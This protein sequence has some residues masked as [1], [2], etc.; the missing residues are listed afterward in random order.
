MATINLELYYENHFRILN[1]LKST[2]ERPYFMQKVAW[3]EQ[4]IGIKG[5]RGVGKTT[6]LLHY[7]KQMYGTN[8][9]CLYIS[10][11]QLLFSGQRL[12]DIADAFDKDGGKLLCVDEIHRYENWSQELKNIYDSYPDLKVIFTGSS[13]LHIHKGK[14]DLSRRAVVYN[15]EG[16]SF[17]EYLQIT[18]GHAFDAVAL[19]DLLK[20]HVEI[21]TTVLQKLK[22]IPA[23]NT[24]LSS[25]YYPYFI[26]NPK[27]YHQKLL[28]TIHLIVDLDLAYLNNVEIRHVHKLKK[29]LYML[30]LSVPYQPNI[31]KL[32][33]T[34]EA[35]RNTIIQYLGYLED[36]NLIKQLRSK[37]KS[38][39]LMAK[40][41]KVYLHNT[42]LIYALSRN[43]NEGNLRETFFYNQLSAVHTVNYPESADFLIDETY[44]FEVGGK[45]KNSEQ[46]KKQPNSYIAADDIEYGASNKVPLWLFGFLY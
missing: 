10:L 42:N 8:K 18:T 29:L 28:E 46:L 36:G 45:N 1:K 11:D 14:S 25:G 5:A 38:Y 20:N 17:R 37:G 33:V 15:L 27:T 32:S 6:L 43:A 19:P 40:A 4:L 44:L 35:T 16:L 39:E 34:V 26:Q 31:S 13:A 41:E 21:A 3:K 2:F 22:P 30:S 12:L 7:I 23:F 9:G 24:Y